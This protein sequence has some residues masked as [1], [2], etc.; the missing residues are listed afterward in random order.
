MSNK[1]KKIGR[2][3]FYF[4]TSKVF[5]RNFL[6]IMAFLTA[7]LFLSFQWMKCYTN[8]GES[9]QV[10]DYV[11]MDIND[12]IKKAERRSFNIIINDSTF[13]PDK[14]PGIVLSQSPIALSRV[15]E[16]R[17]IYLT[18]TKR[19]ADM[20]KI[21]N[22]SGGNDDYNQY[23]KKLK[24]LKLK[25]KII[26]RQFSNKLE[27]NTILEVLYQGDTITEQL[28]KGFEAAKGST[29]GLIITERG[30]GRV[31]IPNLVCQKYQAAQFIID[32]YNLSVGSIIEDA[33][34]TNKNSAYIWR[35][36]PAYTPSGTL[37]I[38]QQIDLYIT[39]Y[40]PDDC[41]GNPQKP[42]NIETAPEEESIDENMD[43][44]DSNPSTPGE[45]ENEDFGDQ[46]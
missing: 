46:K 20:V 6:G 24:S 34:V 26:K 32:N 18:I 10:H 19:I 35:Q 21:P 28:S 1:F 25:A 7:I 22:L 45:E 3:V 9:L 8:H 38:G 14:A 13:I 29:I 12:A 5:I 43:I 40:K 42:E 44:P 4:L 33:T 31:D 16:N 39:Q 37:R 11:G 23:V 27:P 36:K 15:K 2:E 41:S 17:K 30:G